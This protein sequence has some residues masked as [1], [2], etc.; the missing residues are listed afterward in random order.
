MRFLIRVDG[1]LDDHW[2]AWF[3][4]VRITRNG[5]GTSTLTASGADQARLH[6]LLAGLG[7]VGIPLL[8]V[9]AVQTSVSE[10]VPEADRGDRTEP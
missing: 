8:E 10:P 5:D 6:G 2:S 9:R 4:D 7:D 3:A 1:H